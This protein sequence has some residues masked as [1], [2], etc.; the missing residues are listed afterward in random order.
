MDRSSSRLRHVFQFLA[1]F[2]ILAE[3]GGFSSGSK[4]PLLE[5]SMEMPCRSNSSATGPYHLPWMMPVKM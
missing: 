4:K 1:A 3:Q 5:K 2:L